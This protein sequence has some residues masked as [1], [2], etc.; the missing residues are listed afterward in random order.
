MRCSDV[1]GCE[2]QMFPKAR[3][4]RWEQRSSLC[5]TPPIGFTTWAKNLG[6]LQRHDPS[7]LREDEHGRAPVANYTR[8][9][10]QDSSGEPFA[11]SPGTKEPL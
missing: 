10:P 4:G 9:E 6:E 7:C 3:R 5:T 2:Q 11:S 1:P 8:P